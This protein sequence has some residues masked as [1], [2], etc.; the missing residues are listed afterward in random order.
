MKIRRLTVHQLR[1]FLA[2]IRR[3]SFT[4]AGEDLHLTQ[5]AISAQVRELTDLLGGEGAQ[6]L[7]HIVCCELWLRCV[8]MRAH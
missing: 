6:W 2:V 8:G 1:V 4:R 5:S 7:F 3:R